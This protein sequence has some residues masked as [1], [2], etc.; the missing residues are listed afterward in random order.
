MIA[1]FACA[2]EAACNVWSRFGTEVG[3]LES[4]PSNLEVHA[5]AN[6]LW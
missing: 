5:C 1:L 2:R 3:V 6:W 4:A